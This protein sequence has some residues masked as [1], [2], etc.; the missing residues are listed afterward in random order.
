MPP[1]PLCLHAGRDRRGVFTDG[2][3]VD[4]A[5]AVA[6]VFGGPLHGRARR[7][8]RRDRAQ[9][10][11]PGGLN[12]RWLDEPVT[13]LGAVSSD[14][15]GEGP[16]CVWQA[17]RRAKAD[18]SS[19]DR[20]QPRRRAGRARAHRALEVVEVRKLD[21]LRT[22]RDRAGTLLGALPP[23]A[24][25]AAATKSRACRCTCFWAA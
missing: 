6:T 5:G 18:G 1:A 2:M 3:A 21:I 15:F 24:R 12:A 13:R 20:S 4:S 9:P 14:L 8:A 23:G 17:A 10:V 7:P 16:F 19:G 22:G 25:P 11:H